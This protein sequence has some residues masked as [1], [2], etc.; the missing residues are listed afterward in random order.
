[1]P[2]MSNSWAA[3]SGGQAKYQVNANGNLEVSFVLRTVGTRRTAPP[4]GLP[5]ACLPGTQPPVAK[6]IRIQWSAPIQLPGTLRPSCSGRTA[7]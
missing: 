2:A 7:R 3:G 6:Y 1:M 4:S 5:G